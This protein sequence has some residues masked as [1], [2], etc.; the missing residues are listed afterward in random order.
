MRILE[1]SRVKRCQVLIRE[2]VGASLGRQLRQIE[3]ATSDQPSAA[4][5]ESIRGRDLATTEDVG[6]EGRRGQIQRGDNVPDL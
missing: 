3:H 4:D 2:P 5:L 6:E 1:S